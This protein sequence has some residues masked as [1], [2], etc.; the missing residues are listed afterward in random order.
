MKTL[1]DK[2]VVI[3]GAGSGIGRALALEAAARG[4]RLALADRDM[5]G[6]SQT[7][8]MLAP[9][10]K[11]LC[12]QVDVRNDSEVL[13][14]RDAVIARFVSVDV[15]I[16]NAGV[17]VSQMAIGLLRSDFEWVMDVNFWGVVRC[18]EAF[19]PH[20]L[21]SSEAALVN[22]SSLFGLIGIPS[23]SAYNASKFAVR[24]YTE[25]LRQELNAT[26]ICVSCVYPGGVQT[27]IVR[28]GRQYT[29]TRGEAV[30]ADNMAADFAKIAKTSPQQAAAQI[31]RGV[32]ANN[33]R[34]LVGSDAVFGDLVARVFPRHYPKVFAA[35]TAV[36]GRLM[37]VRL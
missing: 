20:L 32:F 21:K 8:A 31:W 35:V 14:F 3:T 34:I 36:A 1:V 25:S 16:N 10:R 30:V 37:G 4:A 5:Q 12:V 26:G 28:N 17:N 29:N 27:G 11:V 6:L 18:T 7:E 33:P 19:L 15:L 2:T 13:Q 23:Q 9:G 22:V 24:G